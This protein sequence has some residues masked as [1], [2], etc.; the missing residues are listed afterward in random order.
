MAIR[1]IN[2]FT[3]YSKSKNKTKTQNISTQ[4]T[5]IQNVSAQNLSFKGLLCTFSPEV[6]A[7][8]GKYVTIMQTPIYELSQKIVDRLRNVED[9]VRINITGAGKPESFWRLFE[10]HPD[11]GLKFDIMYQDTG[12]ARKEILTDPAKRAL[13]KPQTLIDLKNKET[14]IDAC[15][16]LSAKFGA[17]FNP[18]R[19]S[20][21]DYVDIMVNKALITVKNL[22]KILLESKMVSKVYDEEEKKIYYGPL[23]DV[24]RNNK[25]RFQC[26]EGLEY[27]S[28]Y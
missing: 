25:P 22:P 14:G 5:P 9:N 2:T 17:I 21:P 15:L 19:I 1:P 6:A 8:S 27:F 10:T 16:S 7:V 12:R 24:C 18:N 23:F 20:M 28:R 4:N 13:L 26:Y 11:L 3:N